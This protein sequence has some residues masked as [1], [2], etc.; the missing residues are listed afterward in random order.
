M[1]LYAGFVEKPLCPA[2]TIGVI[3]G[4]QPEAARV[5]D[6]SLAGPGGEHVA[7]LVPP[8]SDGLIGEKA[9]SA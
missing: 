7:K 3:G 4:C 1:A 2:A 5:F 6:W 8:G 9:I